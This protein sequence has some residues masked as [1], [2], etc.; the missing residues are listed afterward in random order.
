MLFSVGIRIIY[1]SVVMRQ[2]QFI[3]PV[4]EGYFRVRSLSERK[5]W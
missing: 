1:L 3:I 4:E 2:A 5:E